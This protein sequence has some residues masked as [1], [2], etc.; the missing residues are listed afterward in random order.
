MP[1]AGDLWFE[2]AA[3]DVEGLVEVV[4]GGFGR[5]VRPKEI[6]DLLAVEAVSRCE[7]E[8]LD[9][10]CRLFEAPLALLDGPRTYGNLEAAEQPDPHRLG[11][12]TR[13]ALRVRPRLHR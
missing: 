3:G 2:R 10:G 8:Q 7:G 1:V 13:Y 12:P 4:G 11:P 6:H 5:K 9:E